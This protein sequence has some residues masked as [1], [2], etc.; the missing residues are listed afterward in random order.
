M[1]EERCPEGGVFLPA[2]NLKFDEKQIR[3]L[4]EKSFS[5]NVAQVINLLFDTK[6]DSW[7][8][9]FAI[10]RYPMKLENVSGRAV[11]AE[12]W[13]NPSWKFD[14]LARGIEK[15]MLQSDQIR[16]TDWMVIASRIAVLFGVFGEMI[17]EGSLDPEHPIDL[18]VA[19]GDFSGVMAAVH[20]REWGLPI[21]NIVVCSNENAAAWNLLLK[22][23]LRTEGN[24]I[25][26]STPACDH[27]IPAD[28]ERLIFHNLGSA[29]TMRFIAAC[30]LGAN[31][32]LERFQ[33]NQIH[34]GIQVSVVSGNQVES[35]ISNLYRTS[36]Y[37]AD[38]YTALC[39][40]GLF[41]YRSRTGAARPAVIMADE[42]P[43]H[44][45][46]RIARCLGINP[47]ELK[48]RIDKG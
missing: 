6:L 10:V 3:G 2:Q 24:P 39:Y 12:T 20:A 27:V 25:S 4:G 46:A 42:S 23:E 29:E 35:A 47:M 5:A 1:M 45:L 18:A 37:I 32:Y 40:S 30:D 44:D 33:I 17:R 9:E 34:K 13:H 8:V 43:V 41:D 14:R 22:G 26:T 11:I 19:S 16:Q 48:K 38:P 15:A 7:T 21:E 28:L 36:G 31:Y